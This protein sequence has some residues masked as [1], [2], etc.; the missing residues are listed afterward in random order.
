[1][2]VRDPF[3]KSFLQ[4]LLL[5]KSTF[6]VIPTYFRNPKQKKQHFVVKLWLS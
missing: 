2:W 6:I 1:M 5:N 4:V 3:T